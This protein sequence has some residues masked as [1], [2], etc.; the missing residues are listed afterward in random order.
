MT[1]L[2][3]HGIVQSLVRGKDDFGKRYFK[4][5]AKFFFMFILWKIVFMKYIER[6]IFS[7]GY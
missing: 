5:I 3:L 1:V 6:N 2:S 4:Y 7:R